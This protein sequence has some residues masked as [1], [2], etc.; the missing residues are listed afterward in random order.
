MRVMRGLGVCIY[1]KLVGTCPHAFLYVP[2]TLNNRPVVVKSFL[3]NVICKTMTQ[4]NDRECFDKQDSF[5]LTSHHMEFTKAKKN[6][7]KFKFKLGEYI[8]NTASSNK[9]A[10]HYENICLDISKGLA[11][12]KFT[13]G[14]AVIGP[15]WDLY[16]HSKPQKL[17]FVYPN[18]GYVHTHYG[19]TGCG[20][21]KRGIQNQKD[22]CIRI[23]IPKGNY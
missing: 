12:S 11:C 10:L 15:L 9:P 8:R 14:Q 16:G 5:C 23:N 1:Q 17:L 20:V 19:N 6:A 18:S 3:L 2:V 4:K 21:F 22:F 7:F 13:L